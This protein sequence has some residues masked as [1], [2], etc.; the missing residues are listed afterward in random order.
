MTIDMSVICLFLGVFIGLQGWTLREVTR[1]K[2][3][4]AILAVIIN[5]RRKANE[6]GKTTNSVP[7]SIS[8]FDD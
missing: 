8:G 1:V 3:R 6:T 5:E 7:D 4:V 2:T